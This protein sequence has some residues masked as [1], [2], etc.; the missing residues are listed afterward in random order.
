M[1]HKKLNCDDVHKRGDIWVNTGNWIILVVNKE[2][3]LHKGYNNNNIRMK[4]GTGYNEGA[5]V[6]NLVINDREHCCCRKEKKCE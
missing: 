2:Y 3:S 1:K 5:R 4:I 6:G